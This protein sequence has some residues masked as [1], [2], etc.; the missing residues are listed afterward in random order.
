[1]VGDQIVYSQ[2]RGKTIVG[3]APRASSV[4]PTAAQ[5]A[6][7]RAFQ[8]AAIYAQG[9][10]LDPAVRNIYGAEANERQ[11]S[12]YNIVLADMLQAPDIEEIDL[13]RYTGQVGDTLL[14]TAVDD[15]AVVQVRIRIEN[16][17]GSLVETGDAV[18]QPNPQ[19]W[20]YT[21]TVRNASLAGD[22]ITVQVTDRPGNLDQEVRTL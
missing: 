20:L 15:F 17:D 4:P 7:R 13:T 14:V 3:V 6:H 12:V 22:K 18:Q 1:M 8:Q 2:R 21:A 16:G 11:V 5:I 9:E 10:A 19:Q